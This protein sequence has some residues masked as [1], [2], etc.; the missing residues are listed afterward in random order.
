MPTAALGKIPSDEEELQNRSRLVSDSGSHA[1]GGGGKASSVL[2]GDT[3]GG[4]VSK[5]ASATSGGAGGAGAL[6][7]EDA[8]SPSCLPADLD[9]RLDRHLLP[10]LCC[11]SVVNY[12]DRTNLAFAASGLERDVGITL[13]EYGKRKYFV[14]FAFLSLISFSSTLF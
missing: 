5:R 2:A 11:L 10:A 7:I 3:S 6:S 8:S 13:K 9:R 14:I 1:G 4:F 12:I